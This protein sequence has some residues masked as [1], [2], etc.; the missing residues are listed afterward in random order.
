MLAAVALV[1]SRRRL[2]AFWRWPH[3]VSHSRQGCFHL[4][5]RQLNDGRDTFFRCV[6]T[7]LLLCFCFSPLVLGSDQQAACDADVSASSWNPQRWLWWVPFFTLSAANVRGITSHTQA[8]TH[9]IV[10]RCM[11]L[12]EQRWKDWKIK[13]ILTFSVTFEPNHSRFVFFLRFQSLI[14]FLNPEAVTLLLPDWKII[15]LIDLVIP[16]SKSKVYLCAPS[17][18]HYS[19]NRER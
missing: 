8:H 13:N 9:K 18:A 2:C 6:L 1:G 7:P 12:A 4:Q 14:T 11:Q 19:N 15:L 16:W 5:T 3:E 10:N 17:N